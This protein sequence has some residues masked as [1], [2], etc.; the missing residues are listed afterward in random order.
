M[1]LFDNNYHYA[2]IIWK[3]ILQIQSCIYELEELLDEKTL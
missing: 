1:Y 3:I 2:I